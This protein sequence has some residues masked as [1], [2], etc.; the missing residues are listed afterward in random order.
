MIVLLVVVTMAMAA[1][2]GAE[3]ARHVVLEGRG[4]V[5]RVRKVEV[6]SHVHLTKGCHETIHDGQL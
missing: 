6:S 5:V 1:V 3:G 2:E 4:E